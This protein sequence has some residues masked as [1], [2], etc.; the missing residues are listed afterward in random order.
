VETAVRQ[1]TQLK[2]AQEVDRFVHENG[3]RH[4]T[5]RYLKGPEAREL[6]DRIAQD[7][8]E[9]FVPVSAVPAK[10]DRASQEAV[11]QGQDPRKLEGLSD[12]LINSRIDAAAK[13]GAENVVLVPKRIVD[14]LA[15]HAAPAG[16]TE[17]FFQ[18]VNRPFRFAVLA[19]PKWLTGNFVEP[20][21]VRLPTRGSGIFLPGLLADFRLQAGP[22][23]LRSE[24]GRRAEGGASRRPVHRQPGA[25]NRRTL[26]DLPGLGGHLQVIAK[27][28]VVSRSRGSPSTPRRSSARASSR[29]TASSSASS[30]RRRSATSS[31]RRRRS[32]PGRG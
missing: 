10:L 27:L 13:P 9:E 8:G 4:E 3:L 2:K 26:N 12:Q 14:R 30:R 1:E 5:G 24:A 6:A 16:E 17:R 25:T 11:R 7:T 21:F 18:L 20:F 22:E 23:G 29:S 19:Q 32:S 31:A 28:P 15:A